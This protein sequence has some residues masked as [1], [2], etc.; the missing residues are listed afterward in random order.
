ML[1]VS[2]DESL[3][4]SDHPASPRLAFCTVANV[5]SDNIFPLE[6]VSVSRSSSSP[7]VPVLAQASLQPQCDSIKFSAV[8]PVCTIA[9]FGLMVLLGFFAYIL[10]PTLKKVMAQTPMYFILYILFL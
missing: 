2:R 6:P 5:S 3:I 7:E 9:E 8:V 10:Y 4:T 1:S